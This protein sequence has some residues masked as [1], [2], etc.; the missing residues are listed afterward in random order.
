MQ[1]FLCLAAYTHAQALFS[2]VPHVPTFLFVLRIIRYWAKQRQIYGSKFGYLGGVAWACLVAYACR[3]HPAN[4][5]ASQVYNFFSC[6]STVK[7]RDTAITLDEVGGV[8]YS[9]LSTCFATAPVFNT[10]TPLL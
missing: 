9:H 4:D 1:T 5:T 3:H 6:F 7:W 8:A 10:L 2:R